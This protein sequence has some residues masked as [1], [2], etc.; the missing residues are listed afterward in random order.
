MAHESKLRNEVETDDQES[1]KLISDHHSQYGSTTNPT[2]L[3]STDS[4]LVTVPATKD[5]YFSEES[6]EEM[7][8]SVN[9]ANRK[10]K[11]LQKHHRPHRPNLV[12]TLSHIVRSARQS[13]DEDDL[14]DVIEMPSNDFIIPELDPK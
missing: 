2:T 10:K 1:Q 14:N 7:I 4:S 8:S 13:E 12:S 9:L 11:R 5:P 3:H 6:S